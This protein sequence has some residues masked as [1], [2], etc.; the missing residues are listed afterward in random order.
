MRK[1]QIQKEANAKMRIGKEEL[2]ER[3]LEMMEFI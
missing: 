1:I 3:V 2:N